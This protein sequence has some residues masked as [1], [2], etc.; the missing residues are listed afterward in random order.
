VANGRAPKLRPP[1]EHALTALG[2]EAALERILTAH[3]RSLKGYDEPGILPYSIRQIC[4]MSADA[5]HNES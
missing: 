3:L 1:K 4:L 5:G 2:L